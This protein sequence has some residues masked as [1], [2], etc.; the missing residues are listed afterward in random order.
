MRKSFIFI[1]LALFASLIIGCNPAINPSFTFLPENPR[2]GQTITFTNLTNE[3]E[4]WGWDF[5]DGTYSNYKNPSKIY[6]KPGKY[7]VTLCVDSNKNYITKQDITVYDTL[8]YINISVDSVA[9]YQT[10]TAQALVYNPYNLKVTYKW[11]F[12]AHA[13][14]DDITEGQSTKKQVSLFYNHYNT[15]ETITLDVTI[16]DSTYH[17]QQTFFVHDTPGQ[18]LYITD[19]E[20]NL[21]KQRMYE[22]GIESPVKV[23]ESTYKTFPIGIYNEN[24]LLVTSDAQQDP[25]QATEDATGT[26]QLTAYNLDTWQPQTLLTIH[27]H[28]RLHIS[29][30]S[31]INGQIYWSNYD[32]YTFQ[33]PANITN[34]NFVWNNDS[35]TQSSYYLAGIEHLGYYGHSLHS[36]QPTG[37]ITL[38]A[39]TYFWAKYGSGNGIY[40]FT[41]EDI[42]NTPSTSST[43]LPQSGQILNNVPIKHFCIDAIHRKIYYLTPATNNNELWIC[44]MDGRNA[45]K[46]DTQCTDAL[47]VDNATNR[48]FYADE[49]GI[50]S[51]R[52][53][54]THTNIVT[55]TAQKIADIQATGVVL[56]IQKR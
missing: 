47:W 39:D 13:I 28:P 35:P 44:N 36:G 24:L 33:T 55:E 30:A 5:G 6:K 17:T 54:T 53:I 56:D 21:W 12:S 42:L 10:F 50:K 8:P 14:S 1:T 25:N 38:Y 31:L 9:Y 46:I 19:Q 20:G 7:T 32:D 37:G 2:A 26:C 43:P 40:R 34:E 16:G 29:R 45:T 22:N 15:E 51:I 3:G 48:L 23:Q 49:E 41:K 11:S 52:L 18:A 4:Y 27:Q